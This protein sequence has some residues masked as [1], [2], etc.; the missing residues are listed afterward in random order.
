VSYIMSL[1]FLLKLQPFF[2]IYS[3]VSI[4]IAPGFV[5]ILTYNFTS[6][7]NEWIFDILMLTQLTNYS[8]DGYTLNGTFS[9]Q[10][11]ITMLLSDGEPTSIS[12]QM[13]LDGTVDFTGKET[14]SFAFDNFTIEFDFDPNT[15]R[16]FN[17]ATSGTVS[18]DNVDVNE[19]F[20][21]A[22]KEGL[23]EV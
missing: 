1:Y 9:E 22:L 2:S 5:V 4:T 8:S 21:N 16:I 11:T 23:N 17:I 13:I 14:G 15:G 12:E 7:E 10:Y 18:F 3:E 6:N 19:E 20:A